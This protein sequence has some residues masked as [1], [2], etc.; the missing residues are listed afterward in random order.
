MIK[1]EDIFFSVF[2]SPPFFCYRFIAQFMPVSRDERA[3]PPSLPSLISSQP[4]FSLPLP[5]SHPLFL[6]LSLSKEANKP[7]LSHPNFF[8]GVSSLAQVHLLL[9]LLSRPTLFIKWNELDQRF[10]F[11]QVPLWSHLWGQTF[12]FWD[13]NSISPM[14]KDLAK[15]WICM[16]R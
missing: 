5:L 16:L 6:C 9:L 15:L 7:K 2:P 12:D 1:S 3:L 10:D 14:F 11:D 13:N 8:Q 4:L